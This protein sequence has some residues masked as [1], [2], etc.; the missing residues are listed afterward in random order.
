VSLLDLVLLAE[1]PNVA[2]S[3]LLE[4]AVTDPVCAK[5]LVVEP[6]LLALAARAFVV[7]LD[8]VAL[9]EAE[10]DSVEDADFCP[11]ACCALLLVELIVVDSLFVFELSLVYD[12]SLLAV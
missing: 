5:L 2:P 1:A 12:F 3:D 4:L 7:E 9:E 6:E 10:T 11:P 8:L